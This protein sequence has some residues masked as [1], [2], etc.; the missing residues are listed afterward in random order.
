MQ[1]KI[2]PWSLYFQPPSL[3]HQVITSLHYA[4]VLLLTFSI[5]VRPGLTSPYQA[6][7]FWSCQPFLIP[8]RATALVRF[9][10]T[11]TSSERQSPWHVSSHQIFLDLDV[12]DQL[13]AP[14]SFCQDIHHDSASFSDTCVAAVGISSTE[15]MEIT[16]SRQ[17]C[18]L[19]LSVRQH[20]RDGCCAAA[21]WASILNSEDSIAPSPALGLW[22]MKKNPNS[23]TVTSASSGY[24]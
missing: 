10:G 20:T 16:G 7:M 14:N 12:I 15:L 1:R 3:H 18:K 13:S 6:A 4:Q 11:V 8:S 9:K 24:T 21:H 23:S 5:I 17:S 19:I 2:K 22:G